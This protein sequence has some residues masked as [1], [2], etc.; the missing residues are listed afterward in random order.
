MNKLRFFLWRKS[1]EDIIFDY[2][3]ILFVLIV[4]F[5][6][7]FPFLHM[8]ATSFSGLNAILNNDVIVWPKDI[9]LVAYQKVME[10]PYLVGSYWNSVLYTFVFVLVSLVFTTLAAYPLSK[11]RLIGRRYILFF[12]TFTTIF[13]GGMIPTY[14]VVRNVKLLDSMWSLILPYCTTV[15][16][17]MLLRTFFEG[18]PLELEEAAKLDGLNDVGIMTQ[19]FVP[20]SMP[21]YATLILML[22]VVQWNSFFP[23]LL[24]LS[25][26][27]KHPLQILLREL[28]LMP[29]VDTNYRDLL[30]RY[31]EIPA[32]AA[33]KAAT[34]LVVSLPV[35]V[36]YP[37]LQ[38]YFVKGLTM[39]SVKG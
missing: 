14:L 24:Y 25:N 16:N 11:R 27:S 17:I 2:V 8:I 29:T 26:R 30:A 15:Y 3:N 22:T 28:I 32:E 1:A 6:C 5:L 4:V 34:I 35:L 9:T 38:K 39:G 19:I 31:G 21:M 18:L 7:L 12:V 20:L 33:V 37:F 10:N 23:P 36:V 13:H